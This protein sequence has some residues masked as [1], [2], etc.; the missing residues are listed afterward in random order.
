MPFPDNY[1]KAELAGKLGMDRS[2]L[3]RALVP[4]EQEGLARLGAE[5]WRRSRMLRITPKGRT[6][7]RDASGPQ[8][9]SCAYAAKTAWTGSSRHN[10]SIRSANRA[11]G[12]R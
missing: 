11:E 1:A 10:P 2:T 7:L 8:S 5:G 9:T 12:T 4:L 3:T 6:V